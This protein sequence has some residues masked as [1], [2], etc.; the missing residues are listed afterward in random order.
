MKHMKKYAVFMAALFLVV[1]FAAMSVSA[2][3]YDCNT[4]RHRDIVVARTEPTATTDGEVTLRC[5]LCGREFQR[6]LYATDHLWGEWITVREATCTEYGQ[7]RRT[8]TRTARHHHEKRM[9][10]PL[11]HDY[12]VTEIPPTCGEAG[13]RTYTCSR[14]NDTYTGPGDSALEHHYEATITQESTCIEDGVRTFTC[15]HCG[16]SYIEPIPAIGHEHGEWITETPAQKGVDGME[17]RICIHCGE[18]EERII[19]ALILPEVLVRPSIFNVFDAIAGGVNLLLISLFLIILLPFF[20]T[21]KKYRRDKKA[22]FKRLK[23][24]KEAEAA[25]H[26]FY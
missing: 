26:G 20:H 22:K 18:Q 6:I 13:V 10:P 11:G 1:L 14:C 9:I 5:E 15:I 17:S 4:G 2:V 23:Q 3:Q 21:F 19:A 24:E 25:I 16:D 12:V 7:Q 8:C